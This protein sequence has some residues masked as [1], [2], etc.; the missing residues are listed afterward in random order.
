MDHIP[1]SKCGEVLLM[2][3]M[4]IPAPSAPVFSTA[5]RSFDSYFKGPLSA[6][7]IEALDELFLA[8]RAMAGG[9]ARSRT[10]ARS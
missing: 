5:K 6:A 7:N 2:K 8:S 9:A 3:K 1:E 4:G 10:S